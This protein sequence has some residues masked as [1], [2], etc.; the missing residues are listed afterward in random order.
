MGML[1][2][3]TGLK[4]DYGI[5][6]PG[7]A[8]MF[9]L[10]GLVGVV[11]GGIIWRLANDLP[12]GWQIYAHMVFWPGLS[13]LLTAIAML[14]GSKVGKLWLRDRIIKQL[15]LAGDEQVLDV[16]CGRGLMLLGLAKKLTTGR[17][18]GIDLWQVQDQSG[19]AITT[20]EENARREGVAEKVE[21]HTGD[22]REL[23]FES[24][25]FDI[26]VSSWA[27]HNIPDAAGRQQ[28]I[29]QIDRVLKPNGRLVIV[30]ISYV[31]DYL[32]ELQRL[33]WTDLKRAGPTFHFV[34][35]SYQLWGRKP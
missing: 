7:I 15:P 30:D 22:M 12:A 14:W 20:T 1:N 4:A 3:P 27:I 31:S 24:N 9:L 2:S 17:G 13:F 8:R 19:N 21:L 10:G 5:D 23:P 18:V 33:G 29:Q 28:A 35:P 34:I 16:G 25:R 32:A 6:A 11:V 26:V